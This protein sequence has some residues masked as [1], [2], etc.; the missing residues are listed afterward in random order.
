MKNIKR[1]AESIVVGIT[2]A[3][4]ALFVLSFL[5]KMFL[6]SPEENKWFIIAYIV[7]WIASGLAGVYYGTIYWKNCKGNLDDLDLHR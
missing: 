3:V 7:V 5:I 6:P 1:F 4:F 2:V